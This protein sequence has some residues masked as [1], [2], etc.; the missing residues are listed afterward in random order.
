MGQNMGDALSHIFKADYAKA[1]RNKNS[2]GQ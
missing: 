2:M 1:M